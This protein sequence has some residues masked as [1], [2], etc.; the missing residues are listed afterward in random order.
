[1]SYF[2][3]T[4]RNGIASITDSYSHSKPLDIVQENGDAA[5]HAMTPF[6]QNGMLPAAAQS[7]I[8]GSDVELKIESPP[9]Y[10][11]G[12]PNP[13]DPV[14]A[15]ANGSCCGSQKRQPPA[16]VKQASSSM[17][18]CCGPKPTAE[19]PQKPASKPVS[20]GKSCCSSKPAESFSVVYPS[21]TPLIPMP[22]HIQ[23]PQYQQYQ[24]YQQYANYGLPQAAISQANQIYHPMEQQ[25][26]IFNYPAQFGTFQ[27]PLQPDTW[28]QIQQS[29]LYTTTPQIPPASLAQVV[30]DNYDQTPVNSHFC[31]CGDGCQCLGCP[32]H[33]Y[34]EATQNSVRAAWEMGIPQ[35]N[36]RSNPGD[37]SPACDVPTPAGSIGGES[38]ADDEKVL[39]GSEFIFVSYDMGGGCAGEEDSCPCGDDCEC[40]GCSVHDN[41]PR[42]GSEEDSET[43]VPAIENTTVDQQDFIGHG[44]VIG[45]VGQMACGGDELSCPCGPDCQCQGCSIH[46]SGDFI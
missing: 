13:T 16:P 1:M 5:L 35:D 44:G 8:S 26:Q 7:F 33:P 40:I 30:N 18:S 27:Q 46:R 2:Y 14:P 34:N 43:H 41:P 39:D 28:R 31:N 10:S 11:L 36:K 25:P 23:I 15:S 12:V 32:T 45:V 6:L 20:S 24:Q 22:V 17:G 37:V 4:D 3:A 9:Q 38:M 19:P 29:H 21:E 42:N